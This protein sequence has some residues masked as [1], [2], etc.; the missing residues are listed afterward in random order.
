MLTA[1]YT[2]IVADIEGQKANFAAGPEYGTNTLDSIRAATRSPLTGLPSTKIGLFG[3][4]GGAIGTNWAA[5]LAPTTHRMSI[6]GWSV[7]RRVDCWSTRSAI[8]PTSA[9]ARRGQAWP[10]WRSSESPDPTMS[11][12]KYLSE[13]GKKIVAEMQTAPINNVMGHYP[14]MTWKQLM[15]PQYADLMTVTPFVETVGKINSKAATPTVPLFIA[16]RPPE[17]LR[18]RWATSHGLAKAMA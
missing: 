4:S 14:G 8:S 13:Y 5:A 10:R 9:A 1:G 16:R 3:H 11:T 12:S 17:S 18:A 6:A 7:R 15:K 2:V